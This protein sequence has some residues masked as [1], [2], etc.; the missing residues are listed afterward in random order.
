MDVLGLNCSTGPEHMR[1]PV[2]YLFQHGRTP[3][4]VIPN[5]GIP[6]NVGGEA[7]YPLSPKE[8]AQAHQ[9]VRGGNGRGRGRR[10]LRNHA[11]PSQSRGEGSWRVNP[12][13]ATIGCRT[14]RV[15]SAVQAV[16]LQQIP[17]PT[18]IGERVN[19]QGSRRVKDLLLANDLE[20][21]LQVARE[22]VEGGAHI[23]DV[24]VALTERGDE[25]R[26]CGPW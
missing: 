1:G 22:Q 21:V 5:A 14:P 17:A 24:C 7:V 23:L 20:G 12:G 18:L 2:R 26:P 6:L 10:L 9:G 4:S 13:V 8:L 16:D 19:A 11:G 3:I 15:S 25:A